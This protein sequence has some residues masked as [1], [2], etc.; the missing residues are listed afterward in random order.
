MLLIETNSISN[1]GCQKLKIVRS[2]RYSGY[3]YVNTVFIEYNKYLSKTG[4]CA[5]KLLLSIEK[6]RNITVILDIFPN[7]DTLLLQVS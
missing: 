5:P 6:N 7:I 3:L 4:Q 2:L 1:M